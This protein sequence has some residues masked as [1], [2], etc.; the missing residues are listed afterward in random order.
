MHRAWRL[1]AESQIAALYTAKCREEA[2]SN[3]SALAAAAE[4]TRTSLLEAQLAA[5]SEKHR[6]T[7]AQLELRAVEIAALKREIDR[8][9]EQTSNNSDALVRQRVRVPNNDGF[10]SV[11]LQSTLSYYSV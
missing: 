5:L 4:K 1:R 3:E 8:L 11:P 7:L 2:K 6:S 10:I 9:V